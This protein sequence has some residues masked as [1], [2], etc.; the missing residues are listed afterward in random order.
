MQVVRLASG[1]PNL[2][3]DSSSRHPARNN[4]A[5]NLWWS[6]L[7]SIRTMEQGA[8]V[9]PRTQWFGLEE[10]LPWPRRSVRRNARLGHRC[11]SEVQNCAWPYLLS[12]LSST[13][14]LFL[15]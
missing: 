6:E 15:D 1:V 14:N 12:L 10:A 9:R 8:F 2:D 3:F 13:E 5:M 7:L 4:C 11:N